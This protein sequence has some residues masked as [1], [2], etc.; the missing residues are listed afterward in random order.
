[1][2]KTCIVILGPTAVGKT[3][4]AV[5]VALKYNSQ[6]ISADS[7]QCYKEISIGVAKPSPEQLARV[8]HF[9][10]NSHS[11]HQ[12]VNAAIFESYALSA[13]EKIFQK[14]DIAVLVGGTGLYINAFCNGMDII[15]DSKPG[16]RDQITEAYRQ[17][18]LAWLQQQVKE[19]DPLYFA[20]G[21]IQNPQRLMRALEVKLSTGKSIKEYHTKNKIVRDFDIIKVGLQLPKEDLY[22]NIH[23]RVDE[24]M[25]QGLLEEAEGL[26][27]FR[28]LNALQTV[29]YTELFDYL[30]ENISLEQAVELI[31]KNTRNYAKRQ[32]TWFKKDTST[33]WFSPVD[34]ISLL[35][36]LDINI[37]NK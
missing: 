10:I 24:M 22:H 23:Y 13:V 6:I 37:H 11:I 28:H 26:R 29:G 8:P 31:K 36:Y 19:A 33:T 27:L 34:I 12:E 3:A 30:E 9:F 20:S 25:R 16:L 15:P 4:V 2:R 18:G 14:N 7:R 21:E 5:E 1:M 35:S 17:N 32:M